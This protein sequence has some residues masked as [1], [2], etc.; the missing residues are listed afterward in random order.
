MR[1]FRVLT[2]CG[3]LNRFSDHTLIFS[4]VLYMTKYNIYMCKKK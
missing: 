1:D 3:F 2:P 4:H